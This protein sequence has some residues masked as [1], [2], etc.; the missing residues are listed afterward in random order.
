MDLDDQKR[1]IL[2]NASQNKTP[3]KP[4]SIM[5]GVLND[6]SRMAIEI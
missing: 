5:G 1:K 3:Y 6:P 4:C 2:A